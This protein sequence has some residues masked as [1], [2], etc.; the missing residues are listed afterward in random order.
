MASFNTVLQG[1]LSIYNVISGRLAFQKQVTSTLTDIEAQADSSDLLVVGTSPVNI[2]L[3]DVAID[4][5]SVKNLGPQPL[6]VSF[7]P[8]GGSQA[9]VA[10]LQTN[11]VIAFAGLPEES[12]SVV[13]NSGTSNVEYFITGGPSVGPPPGPPCPPVVVQSTQSSGGAGMVAQV[14]LPNVTAG[15]TIVTMVGFFLSTP[16]A[17][18]LTVTDNKG[19][20]YS[21]FFVNSNVNRVYSCN[22]V[23]NVVGGT[24]TISYTFNVT[25]TWVLQAAEITPTSG[26]SSSIT[27]ALHGT[28][29]GSAFM[30]SAPALLLLWGGSQLGGLSTS[31]TGDTVLQTTSQLQMNSNSAPTV[32]TYTTTWS[33]TSGDTVAA[34]AGL[35]C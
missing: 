7:T 8:N 12:I 31:D 11:G 27:S 20:T 32:G 9:T 33:G 21:N 28:A 13:T 2:A 15:N 34:I 3:P 19:D 18:N 10:T 14:T 6:Q 25:G 26:E 17:S 16:S 22:G 29:V 30:P 24:T 4:T 23:R 1:L 35:F 5:A